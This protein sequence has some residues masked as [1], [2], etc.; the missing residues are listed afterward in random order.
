MTNLKVQCESRVNDS[1]R[2]SNHFRS[3]NISGSA[4]APAVTKSPVGDRPPPVQWSSKS[5]TDGHVFIQTLFQ[6]SSSPPGQNGRHFAVHISRCIL[7]NEKFCILIKISLK[8]VRK[9]P[10]DNDQALV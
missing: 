6:I 9:G 4:L 5:I 7:V 8:F 2:G 1:T 10:I 3:L